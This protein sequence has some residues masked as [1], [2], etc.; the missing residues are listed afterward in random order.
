M[1]MEA[2]TELKYIFA[3]VNDWLKFAEAKHAGLV[4]LNIGIAAGILSSYTNIQNAIFMPALLIGIAFLGV[5]VFLSI[6]SQFPDTE[7][8][9]NSRK[10]IQNPNLYFFENLSRLDYQAFVD[11]YKGI[12][13]NFSPTKFDTDL[14]NQVLV[15]ARIA[16]AKFTLFKLA[17]YLTALGSGLIGFS[18]IVKI[19]WH[20]QKI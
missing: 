19:I 7:N 2:Q 6:V 10:Q 12:D 13:A 4:I 9:V 3:N 1:T 16:Q 11:E 17:S 14:I 20:L 15:N 18:S 8:I 5:S